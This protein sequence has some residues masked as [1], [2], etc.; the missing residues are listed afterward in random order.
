MFFVC[1]S[2][3][4]ILITLGTIASEDCP[5]HRS[6]L[7][8]RKPLREL[9]RATVRTKIAR[10]CRLREVHQAREVVWQAQDFETPPDYSHLWTIT[11]PC[12][13]MPLQYSEGDFDC[14]RVDQA[15]SSKESRSQ[16]FSRKTE[17]KSKAESRTSLTFQR[18]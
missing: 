4:P 12:S 18:I 11:P 2:R 14:T 7:L 13:R 6:G 3:R 15:M 1:V 9:A 5:N 10:V 16:T 17:L 8:D